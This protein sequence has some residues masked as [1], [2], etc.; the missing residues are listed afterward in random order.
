MSFFVCV[1]VRSSLFV[2]FSFPAVGR[3]Q[4]YSS[5]FVQF[6]DSC[7][8]PAEGNLIPCSSVRSVVTTPLP[9]GGVGRGSVRPQKK[10]ESSR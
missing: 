7:P 6:G 4:G 2:K 5:I 10:E 9:L 8:P 3:E 1:F